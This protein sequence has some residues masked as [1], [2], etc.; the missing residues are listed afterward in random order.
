MTRGLN[1]S[2]TACQEFA[3][4]EH[5]HDHRNARVAAA[6]RAQAAGQVKKMLPQKFSGMEVLIRFPS[7][8]MCA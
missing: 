2:E 4:I 6:D 7:A 5:R 3:P 8:K 1:R